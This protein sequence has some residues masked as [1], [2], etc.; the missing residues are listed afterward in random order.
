MRRSAHGAL[1]TVRSQ[2]ALLTASTHGRSTTTRLVARPCLRPQPCTQHIASLSSV[3]E[4]TPICYLVTNVAQTLNAIQT[5]VTSD[6]A[7][8]RLP[9]RHVCQRSTA[10]QDCTVRRLGLIKCV[11][12]S[13]VRVQRVLLLRS[14]LPVMIVSMGHAS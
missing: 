7:R 10:I 8:E 12:L 1:V 3:L 5:T 13:K 4:V 6:I 9:L 2:L 11:L 14:V